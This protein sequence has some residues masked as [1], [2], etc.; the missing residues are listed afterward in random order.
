VLCCVD[1]N[2]NN[3]KIIIE[4][5]TATTDFTEQQWKWA[6]KTEILGRVPV[7]P[8]VFGLSD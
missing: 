7:F 2:K 1:I 5:E 8:S 4:S 3:N 6:P